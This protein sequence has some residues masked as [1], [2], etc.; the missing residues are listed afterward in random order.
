MLLIETLRGT[1]DDHDL[2][3]AVHRHEHHGTAE[4]LSLPREDMARRRLRAVTDQ[5]TEV[6]IAL[7]RDMPLVDRAVLH[8]SDER[9]IVLR[10]EAESWLRLR[11]RDTAEALSLGYAAG[12]LHWRAR[13]DGADLLVALEQDAQLYLDRVE[14]RIADGRIS[15]I[16]DPAMDPAL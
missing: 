4:W 9:V 12:N 6:A 15:H 10:M 16:A 8:L 1:L 7:P 3:E 5:G 11:P 2:H 13:F 14:D